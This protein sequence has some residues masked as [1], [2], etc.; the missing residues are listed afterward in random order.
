MR[1]IVLIVDDHPLVGQAFELS[2]R[3]AYPHLDVG[4]VTTA[5]DAEAFARLNGPRVKLVLLDLMMPDA[6]GFSALLRLQQI[7]PDAAMAIVSARADRHSVSMARAFG[8][9]GYLPKSEPVETLVN[10]VGAFLRGETLFP[11]EVEA[12][13]VAADAH[14]RMAA[15][16]A[17]QLR[18]MRALV[19]GK[20]NKQIAAEM[21]LTEGTVKQHVSAILRKLEV[22]NRSQ[23][24]IAA[25]PFLK[26][27]G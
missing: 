15:L 24:I 25:A 21:N 10:A 13:P 4:R 17:A 16:S 9:R 2:I 27:A 7:L 1:W 19:D 6:E 18:V 3:L 14:R 26:Q 5:A 12:D 23:A 20:L 11:E 8:V 22:T